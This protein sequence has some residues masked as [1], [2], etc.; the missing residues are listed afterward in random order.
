MDCTTYQVT[1][2]LIYILI[3]IYTALHEWISVKETWMVNTLRR[4]C[5]INDEN[6][7]IM[8]FYNWS[9]LE[10]YQF[11]S[12]INFSYPCVK[13]TPTLYESWS[14]M[15]IVVFQILSAQVL[16]R[17][18]Y[19]NELA[20]LPWIMQPFW[21]K[22]NCLSMVESTYHLQINREQYLYHVWRPLKVL[23]HQTPVVSCWFSVLIKLG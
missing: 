17:N 18:L 1:R 5:P 4:N 10:V 9:K 14:L 15:T 3:C 13:T 2:G 21:I 12:C 8:W 7:Y 22:I 11:R 6:Q 20:Q 19:L 23:W 16:I